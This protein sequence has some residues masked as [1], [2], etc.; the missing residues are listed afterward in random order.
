MSSGRVVVHR[1]DGSTTCATF[2]NGVAPMTPAPRK[3]LKI[4]S[5]TSGTAC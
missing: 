3:V 4:S 1:N 2:D 5:D